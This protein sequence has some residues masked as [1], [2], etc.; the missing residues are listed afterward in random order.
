MNTKA[1]VNLNKSVSPATLPPEVVDSSGNPASIDNY[2]GFLQFLMQAAANANLLKIRRLAEDQ[3]S[4]GFVT[5]YDIIVTGT[6]SE[7]ILDSPSQSLSLINTSVPPVTVWINYR[8]IAPRVVRQ[9]VTLNIDFHSHKLRKIF[10]QCTPGTTAQVE[11]V[12]KR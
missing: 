3:E 12:V 2:D 11:I 5:G 10:L 7:V 4:E 6:V 9:N 1:L 8:G